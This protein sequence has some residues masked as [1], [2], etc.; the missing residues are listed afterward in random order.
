MKACIRCGRWH[1][2]AEEALGKRMSCTEVKQYWAKAKDEHL[3]LYGHRAQ[4][5]TDDTENWICLTCGRRI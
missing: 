2:A 4:M 1:E 3:K 5:V